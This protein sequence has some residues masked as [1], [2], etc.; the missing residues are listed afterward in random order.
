MKSRDHAEKGKSRFNPSPDNQPFVFYGVYDALYALF[1]DGHRLFSSF[2]RS[3]LNPPD[4]VKK[5]YYEMKIKG[6]NLEEMSFAREGFRNLTSFFKNETRVAL[7]RY[8]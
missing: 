3:Y 5:G 1:C 7:S 8:L 6:R 2:F 4:K